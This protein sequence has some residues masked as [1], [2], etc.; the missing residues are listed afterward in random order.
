MSIIEEVGKIRARRGGGRFVVE[1]SPVGSSQSN[2]VAE[3]AINS[4]QGQVRV[5]KL[6]LEKRWGIKVPHR[7]SVIPW[8]VA[9]AAFLLNRYEVGHDGK[10]ACKRL[11]LIFVKESTGG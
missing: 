11:G 3:K 2:T 9:Y 1:N 10:T 6:A 4:V 7:H 8:V 5:V